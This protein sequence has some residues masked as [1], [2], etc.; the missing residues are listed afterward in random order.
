MDS[1]IYPWIGFEVAKLKFNY[2]KLLFG[3]ASSVAI[4]LTTTRGH[5]A[6]LNWRRHR[7]DLVVVT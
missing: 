7:A 2:S 3:S 1:N 5:C 4:L 6:V